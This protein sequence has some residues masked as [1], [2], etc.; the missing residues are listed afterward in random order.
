MGE[1]H[2]CSQ[3]LRRHVRLRCICHLRGCCQ[4]AQYAVQEASCPLC[5]SICNRCEYVRKPG[6]ISM[7]NPAKVPDSVCN[8]AS[9]L[10]Y[11]AQLEGK[12]N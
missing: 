4:A 3:V 1:L 12:V 8:L 7:R 11:S 10:P 9:V 5:Y 2:E 6:N